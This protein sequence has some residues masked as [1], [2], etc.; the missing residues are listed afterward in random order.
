MASACII[1]TACC[2][3]G[4]AS[5]LLYLGTCPSLNCLDTFC[6]VDVSVLDRIFLFS[7]LFGHWSADASPSSLFLLF[8]WSFS[9]MGLCGLSTA[10]KKWKITCFFDIDWWEHFCREQVYDSLVTLD[11]FAGMLSLFLFHLNLARFYTMILH[12]LAQLSSC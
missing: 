5:T 9:S 8:C 12:L 1:C 4:L 10:Q 2:A 6:C 11:M 3:S 7:K